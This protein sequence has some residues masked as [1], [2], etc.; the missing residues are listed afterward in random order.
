MEYFVC[1]YHLYVTYMSL[2]VSTM[3]EN[4]VELNTI[5][6]T[7]ES[8]PLEGSQQ[9][10][11][12]PTSQKPRQEFSLP[13]VDGGKDAWLFLAACWAVEALIWGEQK[14][15]RTPLMLDH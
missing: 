9:P 4:A 15:Y 7:L 3:S 11:D 5:G 12:S 8:S 6:S 13:P 14:P 2:C 1:L 10:S